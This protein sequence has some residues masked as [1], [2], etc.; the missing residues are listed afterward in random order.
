M[1]LDAIA[2]HL[3]LGPRTLQRQLESHGAG[4]RAI[5]NQV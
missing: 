1:G 3:V 5:V 2:E 4:F